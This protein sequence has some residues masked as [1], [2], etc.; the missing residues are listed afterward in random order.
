MALRDG[1][2]WDRRGQERMGQ[3]RR[4]QGRQQAPTPAHRRGRVSTHC[5]KLS[6][7]ELS[8]FTCG[9][10]E[11]AEPD[12]A[13]FTDLQVDRA[14]FTDL[15]LQ[16]NLLVIERVVEREELLRLFVGRRH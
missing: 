8:R 15:L 14:A 16:V 2:G 10:G 7:M 12:R 1:T 11:R 3:D 9:D 6:W 5:W 13:A 4:G